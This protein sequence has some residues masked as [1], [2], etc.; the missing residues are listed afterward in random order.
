MNFVLQFLLCSKCIWTIPREIKNSSCL[1]IFKLL[2]AGEC[3]ALFVLFLADGSLPN[4]FDQV[5]SWSLERLRS[6]NTLTLIDVQDVLR[7]FQNG[8]AYAANKIY[9]IPWFAPS[10]KQHFF[11]SSAHPSF[12]LIY[13]FFKN[14]VQSQ[15]SRRSKLSALSKIH[16]RVHWRRFEWVVLMK[17]SG[18]CI[19]YHTWQTCYPYIFLVFSWRKR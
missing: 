15:I 6:Q 19:K 2:L 8:R 18:F 7:Q 11:V 14:D 4:G 9:I 16:V 17:K 13:C 1:R 3:L 5:F 12:P 10:T